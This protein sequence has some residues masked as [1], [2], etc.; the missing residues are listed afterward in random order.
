MQTRCFCLS[1]T[2]ARHTP[3]WQLSGPCYT[4]TTLPTH[5]YALILLSS[6]VPAYS[7]LIVVRVCSLSR[8]TSRCTWTPV[9][10][11]ILMRLESISASNPLELTP[12]HTMFFYKR[13]IS[14]CFISSCAV[15]DYTSCEIMPDRA[16][17]PHTHRWRSAVLFITWSH[18]IPSYPK[19][20]KLV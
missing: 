9:L 5:M 17:L 10:D 6:S 15:T 19:Y 8:S 13:C 1:M 20:Q 18:S 3:A 2:A 4:L 12:S 7:S 16:K 14:L 11:A